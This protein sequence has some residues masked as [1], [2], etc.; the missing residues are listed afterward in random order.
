MKFKIDENLP[1]EV[2]KIF[3]KAGYDTVSVLDQNLGGCSDDTLISICKHEKRV[4][5]TLDT[6]FANTQL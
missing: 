1:I 6:D 4:L 2:V 3:Q 5:I